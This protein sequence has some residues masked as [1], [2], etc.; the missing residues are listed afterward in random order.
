MRFEKHKITLPEGLFDNELL[1]FD[2]TDKPVLKK[3]FNDWVNLCR[4]T[5]DKIGGTRSVNLPESFSEA[6][7][8]IDMNVGRCIKSISGSSSSFDH[9]DL[10]TKKRIQLKGASSYAPSSFGPASQYDEIYCLFFRTIADEKVK[11]KKNKTYSGK[12]EIY[13]LNPNDF[14]PIICN[15]KK[16]ETFLDQQKAGRRPRFS[17]PKVLIDPHN[18]KPIKT[19]DVDLW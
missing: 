2:H 8:S 11:R 10:K 6:V 4:D 14:P 13:K 15:K 7:F 18:L 16:N 1:F 17:I 12:Y 3:Y 9:Y 19:G 5:T